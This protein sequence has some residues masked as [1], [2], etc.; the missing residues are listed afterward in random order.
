MSIR[1][2]SKAVIIHNDA[3]LLNQCRDESGRIYYD[4][5]GG[6][7]HVYESM[8]EAVVREVKEETGYDI[9]VSRFIALAEEICTQEALREQYPEY[10]HRIFHIFGA[11]VIDDRRGAA[12]ETDRGMEDS[13]W[14]PFSR[15]NEIAENCYPY[16]KKL[17]RGLGNL[18]APCYLG[19]AYTD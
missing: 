2:A 12:S 14:I 5:P 13:V 15:I 16:L 9:Q 17:L 10:T 19:T 4:L 11:Q 3:V 6:G 1:C 18:S 7:Q 8:E